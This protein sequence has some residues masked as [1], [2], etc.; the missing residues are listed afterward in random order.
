MADSKMGGA[1]GAGDT[2]DSD[3]EDM[4]ALEEAS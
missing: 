1:D 3:D 2:P 4:P